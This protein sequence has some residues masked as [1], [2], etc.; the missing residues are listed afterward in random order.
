AITGTAT[1]S[2][3]E[4]ARAGYGGAVSGPLSG[5]LVG[6]KLD[7]VVN[8]PPKRDGSL[9]RGHY[10]GTVSDGSVRGSARD[11]AVP[12]GPT[13]SWSGTGPTSCGGAGT[14]SGPTGP[15]SITG[16]WD[17]NNGVWTFTQSGNTVTASIVFSGGLGSANLQGTIS[18]G[19]I[20]ST[21]QCNS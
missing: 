8:M 7:F 14:P 20:Q 6:T 1:F 11:D 21:W 4:G 5:T 3:D 10:T 19:M 17:A 18:N 2:A 15:A 16:T 13:I 9:S 12:N